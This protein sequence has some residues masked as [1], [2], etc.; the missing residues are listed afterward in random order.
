MTPQPTVLGKTLN[1]PLFIM[2]KIYTPEEIEVL[3]LYLKKRGEK[4]EEKPVV[5]IYHEERVLLLPTLQGEEPAQLC[6]IQELEAPY[7]RASLKY[8]K[9]DRRDGYTEWILK[10][11]PEKGFVPL[12]CSLHW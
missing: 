6:W 12:F 11:D 4:M 8:L 3:N 9:G 2:P 7:Y 1:C 5:N 10:L